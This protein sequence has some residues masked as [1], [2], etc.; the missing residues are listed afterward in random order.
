MLAD[1][2][3][4]FQAALAQLTLERFLPLGIDGCFQQLAEGI[5]GRD[6]G[7]CVNTLSLVENCQRRIGYAYLQGQ[8]SAAVNDVVRLPVGLA[9]GGIDD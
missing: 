9:G 8:G 1:T 4:E 2:I 5:T 7:A 3:D 6:E